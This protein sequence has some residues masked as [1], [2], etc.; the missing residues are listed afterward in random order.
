[1]KFILEIIGWPVIR[2]QIHDVDSEIEKNSKSSRPK[3]NLI[4]FERKFKGFFNIFYNREQLIILMNINNFE[5]MSL[6]SS[7]YLIVRSKLNR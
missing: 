6:I 2:S 4:L 5:Q 1:M 3:I 7:N